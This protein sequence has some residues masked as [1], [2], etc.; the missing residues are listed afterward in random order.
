[1]PIIGF[2]SFPAGG[3][4][5]TIT[6]STATDTVLRRVRD[7][8][9]LAHSRAFARARLSDCERF[10]NAVLG[11]FVDN[12]TLTTNPYQCV[13]GIN[14]LLPN[15]TR[16]M[17]VREGGR[18]LAK[19]Q[20]LNQLKLLDSNWTQTLGNRGEAWTMVGRDLLV[21]YPATNQPK[22]YTIIYAKLTTMLGGELDKF[23]IADEYVDR[24]V[25]LCEA[26]L[27]LRQRDLVSAKS[28]IGRMLEKIAPDMMAS[29]LHVAG[30]TTDSSVG[31]VRKA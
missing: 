31:G 23:D 2:P 7:P 10:I 17:A 5:G 12:N 24:V 11:L 3:A 20:D 22:T 28:T 8:N 27:L 14:G 25:T 6:A 19:L 4:T 1:M 21:L 29:P 13:Y 30:P 18:D 26:V 16:V 15:A 9:G